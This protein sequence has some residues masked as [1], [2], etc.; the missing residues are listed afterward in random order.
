MDFVIAKD[1]FDAALAQILQG[2]K[3]TLGDVVDLTADH[4]TLTVV[5][6]GR[7][8]EV[9]IEA[10]AI[11]SAVIPIKVVFAAKRII[12]TY[13][14]ENLRL[15]IR[16]GKFRIQNT[17]ISNPGIAMKRI[18]RRIIDIP[19]DARPMDVLA[20]RHL[21][22]VD[23]IED[24]GLH[25]KVLDAQ[26]ELTRSLESASMTLRDY[27]VEQAELIAMVEAKIK[28]HAEAMKH[29]LFNNNEVS[30]DQETAEAKRITQSLDSKRES[31]ARW[32]ERGK[33]LLCKEKL[34]EAQECFVAGL[35]VDP[36][37]AELRFWMGFLCNKNNVEWFRKAAKHGHG[38]AAWC[39]V[40]HLLSGNI[41]ETTLNAAEFW[42]NHAAAEGLG[43]L[44]QT[45]K[46]IR[47]RPRTD[48][49]ENVLHDWLLMLASG[50]NDE[51]AF[52]LARFRYF[53][54]KIEDDIEEITF[55]LQETE[56]AGFG[57]IEET[58]KKFRAERRSRQC[59]LAVNSGDRLAF[60][61]AEWADRSQFESFLWYDAN[62]YTEK[63]ID[64]YRKLFPDKELGTSEWWNVPG[65]PNYTHP[66]GTDNQQAD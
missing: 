19:D 59:E 40:L 45:L 46:I 52:E 43:S 29:V 53:A 13:K 64:K 21:F 44:K 17:S 60:L 41:E 25:V 8:L 2:R 20:L 54:L 63:W 37:H 66:L 42:F 10:E 9:P 12:K 7:S 58:M 14:D 18:A 55:W 11:G 47:E 30:Q 39:M 16:D 36:D 1:D 28:A 62:M 5:A 26:S 27:G 34:P 65:G 51:A 48:Q 33:A 6:T 22:S 23:E 24:S 56:R 15:C 3:D 38:E 35:A 57:T 50:G 31:T 32:L 61:Y 4:S 49:S